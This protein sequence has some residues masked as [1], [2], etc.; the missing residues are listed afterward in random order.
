MLGLCGN[1]EMNI[2]QRENRE[3]VELVIHTQ[4]V[5]VGHMTDKRE[6]SK[7]IAERMFDDNYPI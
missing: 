6:S 1:Y 2:F 3:C 4:V 7:V 5:Y